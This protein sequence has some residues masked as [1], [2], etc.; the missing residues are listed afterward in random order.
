MKVEIFTIHTQDMDL[1]RRQYFLLSNPMVRK[2]FSFMR[3]SLT[4]IITSDLQW[5][6]N[7]I[8]LYSSLIVVSRLQNGRLVI[9]FSVR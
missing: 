7:S 8:D 9:H 5:N 6:W 2:N 1:L 3:T 4:H